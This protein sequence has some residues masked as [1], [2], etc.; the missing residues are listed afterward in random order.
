[1]RPFVHRIRQNRE[2]DKNKKSVVEMKVFIFS[3]VKF[4]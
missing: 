3:K 1:M 2:K 4:A